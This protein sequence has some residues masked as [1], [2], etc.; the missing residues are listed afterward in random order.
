VLCVNE[1]AEAVNRK[2]GHENYAIILQ[3]S[4]TRIFTIKKCVEPK[5]R[6]KFSLI[7]LCEISRATKR[8]G[9]CVGTR[10]N[11]VTKTQEKKEG[12]RGKEEAHFCRG[13]APLDL[14]K[15]VTYIHAS[16]PSVIVTTHAVCRVDSFHSGCPLLALPLGK[17]IMS[18]TQST[19]QLITLTG[20][21]CSPVGAVFTRVSASIP[22]LLE[23]NA[24]LISKHSLLL[25]STTTIFPN[26]HL[27]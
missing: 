24:M 15:S 23:M 6:N 19:D 13:G 16:V 26:L 14:M 27:S 20:L 17:I 10:V 12:G 3:V 25:N 1:S 18:K 5:W 9:T 11:D 8:R 2:I 21:H 22:S 4:A 7:R